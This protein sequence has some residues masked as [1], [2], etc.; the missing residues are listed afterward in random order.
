M[1]ARIPMVE[2]RQASVPLEKAQKAVAVAHVA[3]SRAMTRPFLQ[4]LL[5]R[6]LGREISETAC[7]TYL[8]WLQTASIVLKLDAD[9][10]AELSRIRAEG[11]G[12]Q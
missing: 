4:R 7:E 8:D 3:M 10:L 2:E 6:A 1:S 12:R 11:D 5:G 9:T